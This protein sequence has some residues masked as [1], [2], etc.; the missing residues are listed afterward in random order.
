MPS[1]PRADRFASA[2]LG[3]EFALWQ[4][5][6]RRGSPKPP[7]HRYGIV[8]D[9]L[10]AR[11]VAPASPA[12]RAVSAAAEAQKDGEDGRTGCGAWRR[13]SSKIRDQAPGADG[14]GP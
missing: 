6:I 7:E 1:W 2:S 10:L 4:S 14:A 12:P 5:S 13:T 8:G 9:M 3:A 11:N